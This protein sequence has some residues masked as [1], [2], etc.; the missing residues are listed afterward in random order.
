[1]AMNK[2]KQALSH[3]DLK[4]ID[5]TQ[6]VE[7]LYNSVTAQKRQRLKLYPK[8][9]LALETTFRADPK[10]SAKNKEA[11]S[12]NL[13]IQLKNV[14]VWFQ[15]R[16]AKAKNNNEGISIVKSSKV[17][18]DE[19]ISQ[20]VDNQVDF[21]YAN[22]TPVEHVYNEGNLF[23]TGYTDMICVE[24]FPVEE[25]NN[26]LENVRTFVDPD[27][28][29]EVI[30]TGHCSQHV[31]DFNTFTAGKNIF[32]FESNGNEDETPFRHFDDNNL[33]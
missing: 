27:G 7:C 17:E 3:R 24:Q 1:M 22:D 11:L 8:Q 28:H 30:I 29:Q 21:Y 6:D 19:N 12:K 2:K 31:V 5:N 10:P 14:Q 32:S 25:S 16:R 26:P 18:N 23:Q 15:N 33:K 20:A 4:F 13:G 9:I